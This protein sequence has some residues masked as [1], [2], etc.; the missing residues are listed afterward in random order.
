MLPELEDYNWGEA[1]GYAGEKGKCST[2]TVS[3]ALPNDLDL[4][5]DGFCR[6]DVKR[7]IAMD[8]G[9]N[10]ERDWL[11]VGELHDGRFFALEAGC[12]YTG[13]D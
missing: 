4:S 1:F 12:D 9:E 10:D 2:G 8:E 13:W 11:I 3:R 6:E 5:V 7:I